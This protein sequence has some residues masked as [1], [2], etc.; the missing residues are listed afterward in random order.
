[1]EDTKVYITFAWGD[2]CHEWVKIVDVTDEYEIE[3][4]PDIYKKELEKLTTIH[5][6]L[7]TFEVELDYDEVQRSFSPK[8]LKSK[9]K[10]TSPRRRTFMERLWLKEIKDEDFDKEIDNEIDLWH[11]DPSSH[12]YLED[13]LGMTK[14]Q[15]SMWL[16]DPNEFKIAFDVSSDALLRLFIKHVFSMWGTL[17][18]PELFRIARLK[19]FKQRD[20]NRVYW[21]MSRDGEIIE[22]DGYLKIGGERL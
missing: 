9:M 13:W 21:E 7:R 1:M 11:S 10:F 4:D 17:K 12:L 2:E 20:F 8:I 14:D 16:K 22:V 18:E 19:S 3:N 15:Y 6:D 5:G